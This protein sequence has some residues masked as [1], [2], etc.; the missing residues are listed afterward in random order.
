MCSAVDGRSE[1]SV[2]KSVEKSVAKAAEALFEVQRA[3]GSWPNRRPTAVLGTAG[4]LAALHFADRE[5]SNDLIE[6]GAAWLAGAQNADGGWGGVAG[7]STQLVPTVIAAASLHL[8]SPNTSREPVQRALDLVKSYGG[9]EALT[10]PGMAHMA[11]T[12]L[13][14][15]GLQD[16][17]ASRR[18]PL[19]LLLLPQR[20]WRRRLSFRVAPFIAMAFIQARHRPPEAR[21]QRLLNR[22]ARP[23]G[24]RTLARVERGENARGG[25]GGDNWL[26]AVVCLGLTCAGAPRRAVLDAVDYL[27]ANVHP[28]GSWHIMQGLDLIGGSYVARG[29]ADAGYRADPRLV[30]ARQWL[31]GCQQEEAFEVYGAPPGGW[32]WEGPRGWPNFLDSANVLAAL[33]AGGEAGEGDAGD[34]HLR[35]GLRWLASRQD[36]QGSWG[37]FVP[38]TTLPNDGPCPYVTAQC[39]EVLLD[40]GVSRRHPVVRKALDWL[41]AHQRSDGSY[42]ALWYRGL[43][44]GTAMAL[45]ALSRA[46]LAGHPVA[47]RARDALLRNQLPDGSWGPGEKGTP[48][49]DPSPGTVEETAWALR[50]LL[51]CGMPADDP[52]VRRA[53]EWI[54]TAQRPDGRWDASAVCMHIRGFASYVDG[55]IVDGLALKALGDYRSAVAGHPYEK[56]EA[57]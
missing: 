3:D 26:A 49:D 39:A 19:E 1:K 24:L 15:A 54:T 36:R 25:Y 29:L 48:G 18:I 17:H 10:D 9:T 34:A 32:G 14:L 35:R 16:P 47:R 21:L 42:E 2:T 11:A 5:R 50:A 27:R 33:A 44:P 51:A 57:S 38:D 7:A 45:V 12:F 23:A 4:A 20:L 52:R 43:T 31:R 41:L 28:D 56:Q 8:V 30:R 6:R 22:L 53:A 13:A 55:L 37:T 40:G 46:G